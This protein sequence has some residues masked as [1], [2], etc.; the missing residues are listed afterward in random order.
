MRSS[1]I[2]WKNLKEHDVKTS[3]NYE[4]QAVGAE[5]LSAVELAKAQYGLGKEPLNLRFDLIGDLSSVEGRYH[6]KADLDRLLLQHAGF[7]VEQKDSLSLK[8][9]QAVSDSFY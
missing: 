2:C 1:L 9:E 7:E 6:C 4:P 5:S 3:I 8:F